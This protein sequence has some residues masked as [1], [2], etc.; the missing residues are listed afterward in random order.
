MGLRKRSVSLEVESCLKTNFLTNRIHFL[1]AATFFMFHVQRIANNPFSRL[2]HS[3][4]PIP[5]DSVPSDAPKTI[6]PVA[7][8]IQSFLFP[9]SLCRHGFPVD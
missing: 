6:D 7:P 1:L 9:T 2:K 4:Y 3:I 5:C 8:A